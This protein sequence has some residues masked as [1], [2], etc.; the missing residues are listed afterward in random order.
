[1]DGAKA[2][3]VITDPPYNVVID[4]VNSLGDLI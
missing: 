1:M 3:L 4:G 2:E